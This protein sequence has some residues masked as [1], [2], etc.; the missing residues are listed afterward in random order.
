[1]RTNWV[2]IVTIIASVAGCDAGPTDPTATLPADIRDFLK[3]DPALVVRSG[4]VVLSDRSADITVF[5]VSYGEPQDCQSGCFYSSAIGLRV[6]RQSG[7]VDG[8]GQSVPN[9]SVFRLQPMDSLR[10]TTAYLDELKA[11]DR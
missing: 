6:G 3:S 5:R 10:F 2:V 1:M 11:R 7:W 4:A 8:I 9:T